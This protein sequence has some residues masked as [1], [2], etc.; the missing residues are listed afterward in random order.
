MA[1]RQRRRRNYF[2]NRPERRVPDR[3]NP[4]E[5]YN[6]GQCY[7]KFRFFP[8]TILFIC[9]LVFPFI[10]R[11]Q[12]QRKALTVPQSVCLVL[13]ILAGGSFYVCI[14]DIVSVSK[15]TVCREVARIIPL[16]ANLSNRFIKFP[17]GRE[18]IDVKT[19]FHDRAGMYILFS[20]SVSY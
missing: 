2:N 3:S 9:N 7:M 5:I 18:I 20:V 4:L 11:T 1:D 6:R 19:A 12:N 8:E 14:G 13:R 15:S 17:S 10:Q 16:L